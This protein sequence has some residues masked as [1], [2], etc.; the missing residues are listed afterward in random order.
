MS[1]REQRLDFDDEARR[2]YARINLDRFATNK[3]AFYSDTDA[4]YRHPTSGGTI[5]VG[6]KNAAENLPYLK[7]LGIKRVVN[8]THGFSKIPDFHPGITKYQTSFL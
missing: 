1:S 3:T 5:Y 7:S 8:C 2:L 6:N 4:I